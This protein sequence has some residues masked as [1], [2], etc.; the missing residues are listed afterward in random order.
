M[1]I[2]VVDQ[3]QTRFVYS[4]CMGGDGGIGVELPAAVFERAYTWLGER[5]SRNLV[6]VGVSVRV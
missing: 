3:P 2:G 5:R 6:R 4:F 1:G